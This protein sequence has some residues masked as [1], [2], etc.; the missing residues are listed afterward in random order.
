MAAP[1]NDFF[2]QDVEKVVDR[3]LTKNSLQRGKLTAQHSSSQKRKVP[4][5]R[6]LFFVCFLF[7]RRSLL[8]RARS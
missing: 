6:G 7:E 8:F 2:L 3:I 1:T 5:T 4:K